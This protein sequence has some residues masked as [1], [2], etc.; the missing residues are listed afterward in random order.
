MSD[1]IETAC[2]VIDVEEIRSVINK[3]IISVPASIK[4]LWPDIL[5]DPEPLWA[6]YYKNG[7]FLLY[8][9][10]YELLRLQSQ[11][12]HT[13]YGPLPGLFTTSASDR[14]LIS[15]DRSTNVFLGSNIC[16]GQHLVKVGQDCTITVSQHPIDIQLPEFGRVHYFLPLAYIIS[17]GDLIAEYDINQKLDELIAASIKSWSSRG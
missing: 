9:L 2:E 3:R 7:I 10:D 15:V 4:Y 13:K 8:F 5:Q 17:V 14:C 16:T 12:H 6:H 1:I 11:F